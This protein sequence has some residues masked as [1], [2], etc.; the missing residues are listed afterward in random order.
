[1]ETHNLARLEENLASL[2][3]ATLDPSMIQLRTMLRSFEGQACLALVFALFWSLFIETARRK[4]E[5][6]VCASKW[7]PRALPNQISVM[8][9]FGYDSSITED[10]AVYG[11]VWIIT[12]CITHIVSASLMLPVVIMGWDASGPVGQVCFLLGTVSEVGFDIYDLTK[13]T[14]LAFFPSSFQA[15]GPCCPIKTFM[16]IGLCHH[17]TVLGMAIPMNMQY[18]SI[19]AYHRAAFSLLFS[20]GVC[21]G[22]GQYK[23]CLDSKTEDGL[24][25]IKTIMTVQFVMNWVARV[26]IWFPCVFSIL[27]TFYAAGDAAFFW[28]ACASTLGMSF[29]N[30]AVVSDATFSFKKWLQKPTQQG[31]LS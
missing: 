14:L 19:A 1:M 4:L 13:L 2:N 3:L 6:F 16:L 12:M 5:A 26:W 17:T 18:P 30:L 25:K 20:A 29:Y 27:S 24:R 23:F 28:F 31:K 7:W 9:N 15:L 11:F 8:V 21:Y 10:V 22:L